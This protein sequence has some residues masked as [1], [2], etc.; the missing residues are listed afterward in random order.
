MIAP[1]VWFWKTPDAA[2]L[3]L[4]VGIGI[5]SL[6]TQMCNIFAFRAAEASAI[7]A[8]DYTRLIWGIMIGFLVFSEWPELHVF[9]GAAIII[10]AALYTMH[11][12]SRLARRQPM[13]PRSGLMTS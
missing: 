2:E 6:L 9:L 8:I 12:E 11:R 3:L 13:P 1:T 4:L 7:A 10:G 5:V